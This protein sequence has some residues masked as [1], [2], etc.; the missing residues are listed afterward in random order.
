MRYEC[1]A[2]AGVLPGLSPVA[3]L[4]A[5]ASAL[6]YWHS[7]WLLTAVPLRGMDAALLLLASWLLMELLCM[8]VPVGSAADTVM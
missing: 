8:A 3:V 1:C 6:C 4:C 7:V 2:A 5:A